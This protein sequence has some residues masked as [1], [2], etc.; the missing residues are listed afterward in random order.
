MESII[1]KEKKGTLSQALKKV[2][3]DHEPILFVP[4]EN[5][6]SGVL[7]AYDDFK[8]ME[9][10]SYLL[11]SPKNAKRLIQSIM[12]IEKGNYQKHPLIE[13]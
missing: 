12:E 8:S 13:D 10:I 2:N 11:R 5:E 4:E 7:I 9:E 6:A 3:Q 1:L